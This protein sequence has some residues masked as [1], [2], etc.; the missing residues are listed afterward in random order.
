LVEVEVGDLLKVAAA[1]FVIAMLVALARA[2]ASEVSLGDP[3]NLFD[4]PHDQSE[5]SPASEVE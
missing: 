5:P 1:F 3:G 4:R 2:N